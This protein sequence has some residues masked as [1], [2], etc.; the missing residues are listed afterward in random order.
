MTGLL[1]GSLV[2]GLAGSPHC[3]GMCGGFAMATARDA[4]GAVAWHVGRLTTYGTLGAL[5]GAFGSLVPGPGWVLTVVAGA[6]LVWFAAGLAGLVKP[7]H[8]AIPGVATASS[9]MLRRT[10][11][12]ARLVL[13][14][15][16]GLLPCGLVYAAL[17]VPV[18][19]A[20]PLWGALA[21]VTF[22]VGTVPALAVAAVGLQK[23]LS[24]GPWAR[25]ILAAG[26]LAAGLWSLGVRATAT[27]TDEG[28]ACHDAGE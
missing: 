15:L 16:S 4:R 14:A 19:L 9:A 26:V 8:A 23:L 3:A 28:P 10:G 11:L 25:R 1:L 22:G 24:R 12:G 20:D 18:A 21:M 13:G 5:A 6:L 27:V 17:S 2:A 7:V